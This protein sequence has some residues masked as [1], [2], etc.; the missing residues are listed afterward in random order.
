M[1]KNV[2]KPN[3][4]PVATTAVYKDSA[5]WDSTRRNFTLAESDE[6]E[7]WVIKKSEQSDRHPLATRFKS[8]G[9]GLSKTVIK[10]V[11]TPT[12]QPSEVP[13][14]L[15]EDEED[16]PSDDPLRLP[17]IGASAPIGLDLGREN[18]PKDEVRNQKREES[19]VCPRQ[20]CHKTNKGAESHC[21]ECKSLRKK[22]YTLNI[23]CGSCGDGPHT[24]HVSIACP[25]CNQYFGSDSNFAWVPVST[26]KSPDAH[27][28]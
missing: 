8:Q 6:E 24:K 25:N 20:N 11:R 27:A 21:T 9:G 18:Y 22:K 16:N 17:T 3:Y 10:G 5:E 23:F 15:I 7:G 28:S 26:E 2:P 19:W 14:S 13:E 1:V 12:A 4:R